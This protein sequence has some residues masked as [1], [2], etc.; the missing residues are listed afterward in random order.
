MPAYAPPSITMHIL[1]E[2]TNAADGVESAHTNTVNFG[3]HLINNNIVTT[4]D[5]RVRIRNAE[6]HPITLERCATVQNPICY[7]SGQDAQHVAGN[8][9]W[10]HIKNISDNGLAVSDD[11]QAISDSNFTDYKSLVAHIEA[12]SYISFDTRLVIPS[13]AQNGFYSFDYVIEYQYTT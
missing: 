5:T 3:S 12:G 6:I 9:R 4:A 8:N 7:I 13:S 1:T 10:V 2:Y 11:F